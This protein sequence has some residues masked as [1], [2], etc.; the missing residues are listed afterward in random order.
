ML[1]IFEKKIKVK[2]GGGG[3]KKR[4]VCVIGQN[5]MELSRYVQSKNPLNWINDDQWI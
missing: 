1:V 2:E 4:F 3:F 5:K